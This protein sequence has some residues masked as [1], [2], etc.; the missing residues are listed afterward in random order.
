MTKMWTTGDE[1]TQLLLADCNSWL[2][3]DV[4]VH[5]LGS[6]TV[7]CVKA[8]KNSFPLCVLYTAFLSTRQK[9]GTFSRLHARY[10]SPSSDRPVPFHPQGKR[11]RRNSKDPH[12]VE[13]KNPALFVSRSP[14]QPYWGHKPAIPWRDEMYT[15]PTG[16]VEQEK[17][18]HLNQL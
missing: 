16:E 14:V 9:N 7:Q 4:G 1:C 3:L 8:A 5:Y 6:A 11:S 13:L 17:E 18:V 10:I 12:R 2:H 15:G